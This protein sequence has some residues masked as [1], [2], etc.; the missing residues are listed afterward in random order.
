[1]RSEGF[2]TSGTTIIRLEV[3][4]V[5][6][7]G[8]PVPGVG[9]SPLRD[10]TR[11]TRGGAERRSES[12]RARQP[13]PPSSGHPCTSTRQDSTSKPLRS[14]HLTPREGP[15]G[16]AVGSERNKWTNPNRRPRS[17]C[18]ATKSTWV[19]IKIGGGPIHTNPNRRPHSPRVA[20]KSTWVRIKS[21]WVRTATR[22]PCPAG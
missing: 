16:G 7:E 1:M 19:R 8:T 17:P 18:V 5:Q 20:G 13:A 2:L 6:T 10:T 3:D 14:R 15:H 11:A 22:I 9:Q 21:T 4:G 12:Y